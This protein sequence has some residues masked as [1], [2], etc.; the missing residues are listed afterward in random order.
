MIA[1]TITLIQSM[2][3]AL[4]LLSCTTGPFSKLST[5]ASMR[6]EVEVYKGPLSKDRQVQLGEIIG[7]IREAKSSLQSF[8]TGAYTYSRQLGCRVTNKS[9]DCKALEGLIHSTKELLNGTNKL[10]ENADKQNIRAD[11][12]RVY[13]KGMPE[14]EKIK[15]NLLSYTTAVSALAIQFKAKS[16][17]WAEYQ[18]KALSKNQRVRTKLTEFTTI[19][20]EFSN[21]LAS[22]TTV[23]YK[24]FE[25]DDIKGYK[26]ATS[27]HLRDASPTAFLHLFDWYR[28]TYADPDK[29][30]K[31]TAADRVRLAQQLFSDH[32]WTKINEVHA[33]GQGK[34]SMALIK[35]DI[36]NWNLKSFENNPTE[37]LNAYRKLSL[38]GIQAAVNV[39]GKIAKESV[40]GAGA[41]ELLGQFAQGRVSSTRTALA[42]NVKIESL[43]VTAHGDLKELMAHAKAEKPKLI[44]AVRE[45]KE[46]ADDAN[47]NFDA[48]K[49]IFDKAAAA[50]KTKK[51]EIFNNQQKYIDQHLALE[52]TRGELAVV[53]NQIAALPATADNATR[54]AH[55]DKKDELEKKEIQQKDARDQTFEKGKMLKGELDSLIM[56]E[57]DGLS[58]F[59]EAVKDADLAQAA[60]DDAREKLSDFAID[61]LQ[62]ARKIMEIHRRVILALKEAQTPSSNSMK[63]SKTSSKSKERVPIPTKIL[64]TEIGP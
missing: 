16:F 41:L 54:K 32:Y 5:G 49:E 2:L 52:Q 33:S 6:V 43:S 62:E 26:L 21:Q 58:N 10:L 14:Y 17:F 37:L 27:D 39:A 60:L 34:V 45:A 44:E 50:V 46:K 8:A 23:L 38:A 56:T 31:M 51:Q 47:S 30:S 61:V 24:Q 19:T 64:E 3:I 63:F 22:R 40:P 53:K 20:S 1:I 9:D 29:V 12:L 7:V 55:L 28:A 59:E 13:Q 11:K 36:G 42:S 15:N 48:T 35:D 4:V 57:K 25:D 18:I